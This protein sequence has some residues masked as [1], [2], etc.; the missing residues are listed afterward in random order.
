MPL[1]YPFGDDEEEPISGLFDPPEE[2]VDP[3]NLDFANLPDGN[4]SNAYGDSAQVPSSAFG[5]ASSSRGDSQTLP[6]SAFAGAKMPQVNS[7]GTAEKRYQDVLARA[8]EVMQREKPS[9][10]RKLAA[11]GTGFAQG[12]YNAGP[13]GRHNPVDTSAAVQNILYPGQARKE[14]VYGAEK[15]TAAEAAKAEQTAKRNAA[16]EGYEGS[17]GKYYEGLNQART[18]G[19][20]A[21]A[22][23]QAEAAF[24]KAGG[25]VISPEERGGAMSA[26]ATLPKMPQIAPLEKPEGWQGPELPAPD[27]LNAAPQLPQNAGVSHIE[28]NGTIPAAVPQGYNKVPSVAGDEPGSLRARP[29]FETARGMVAPSAE[30]RQ[31]DPTLP[32]MIPKETYNRLAGIAGAAERQD[33]SIEAKKAL[34]DDVLAMREK[35]GGM[36]AKIKPGGGGGGLAPV[37]EQQDAHVRQVAAKNP[38]LDLDAWT[39]MLERKLNVRGR[40]ADTSEQAKLIKARAGQIMND[41]GLEPSELY[42]RGGEL[43]SNLGAFSKITNQDTMVRAF[44]GTL[45]KNAQLA[46]K[47]SEDYKRGD[48]QLYN[49]V[50]GAFKTGTGDSEALALSAQLHGLANEWGKIMAGSTGSMGVPISEANAANE[51]F[52]K[53]LSNGQLDALIKN[54]MIPDAHNRAASNQEE[55]ERLLGSIRGVTRSN[56]PDAGGPKPNTPNPQAPPPPQANPNPN[57]YVKGHIYGGLEFLGGDPLIGT[58]WKKASGK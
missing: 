54:V 11:A 22:K 10:L 8:P 20:E 34:S 58:S 12:Y 56:K 45:L 28:A 2:P 55:K 50:L 3:N 39:Y 14:A 9:L 46:Q 23:T 37:S 17:R 21:A 4:E 15:E 49:R 57:G 24:Q 26:D 16:Y 43:K 31:K 13:A 6:S 19:K 18:E 5:G 29:S 36:R 48:L 33:K 7:Q 41:L 32:A 27:T 51:F 52:S 40:G 1:R 44:E 53:G 42:A 35:L 47:L 25:Q 38:A 30:M